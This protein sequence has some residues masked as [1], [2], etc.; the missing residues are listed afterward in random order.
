MFFL[1][2]DLAWGDNR[3]TGIAVLAAD[4]G[5]KFVGAALHDVEIIDAVSPYVEG[6]CLVAIDA[7]LIVANA[8]GQRPAERALNVRFSSFDAGAHSAN[9][10]IPVFSSG[11]RGARIAN[12]LGLNMHPSSTATRRAI[13]VYPHPATVALFR[14]GRTLKYKHKP[15][16]SFALLQ[17]ELLRL[18]RLIEDLADADVSMR[19][20]ENP[21]WVRLRR[22]VEIATTKAELRRAED[23]VDAVLCAYVARYTAERPH[24]ITIYGDFETGY[25]ITPTLPPG[26]RP[27]PRQFIDEPIDGARVA[28]PHLEGVR[29]AAASLEVAQ[30]AL[31]E[32]VAQFRLRGGSWA[33]IGDVLGLPEDEAKRRFG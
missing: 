32:A 22:M 3:P 29:R 25:I 5:L 2:L 20:A 30:E 7:P 15:K 27:S 6:E 18:I 1:G 21:D 16:R 26:L 23:P 8:T 4:G 10:G 14:L 17:S 11:P 12:A 28:D 24:D 33:V 9:T 31:Q 19:V 13:E